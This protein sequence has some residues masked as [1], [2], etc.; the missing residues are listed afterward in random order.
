LSSGVTLA[1]RRNHFPPK[2]LANASASSGLAKQNTTK[3]LS[4]RPTEYV[5]GVADR[6]T[7]STKYYL[8]V[9][10]V[11]HL[12]GR[13]RHVMR[14]FALEITA[15]DFA[16]AAGHRRVAFVAGTL[17]CAAA[18]WIAAASSGVSTSLSQTALLAILSFELVGFGGSDFLAMRSDRKV[19]T[20]NPADRLRSS[21]DA[22]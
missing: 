6:T 7:S 14:P 1:A 3:S 12:F 11:P 4:S 21:G 15:G 5:S 2:R 18:F 17:N 9:H 13:K 8:A 22:V 16:L 19:S 20:F 10:G